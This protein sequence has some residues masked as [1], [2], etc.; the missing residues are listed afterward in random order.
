MH[1]A[2]NEFK[3]PAA[4]FERAVTLENKVLGIEIHPAKFMGESQ[5]FFRGGPIALF[6]LSSALAS[7]LYAK[8]WGMMQLM[9]QF[10]TAFSQLDLQ[11]ITHPLQAPEF[12]LFNL[13]QPYQDLRS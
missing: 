13:V 3:V 6:W 12:E 8:L 2:I 1:Y 10:L 9:L 11:V 7:A 4:S 5:G